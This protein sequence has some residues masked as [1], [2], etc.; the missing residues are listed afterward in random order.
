M[1]ALNYSRGASGLPIVSVFGD[2]KA[3]FLNL[4]YGGDDHL[5]LLP[6]GN[7]GPFGNDWFCGQKPVLD[8]SF[9]TDRVLG[10][11]VRIYLS[12]YGGPIPVL[13]REWFIPGGTGA[14]GNWI[15][16]SEHGLVMPSWEFQVHFY[17]LDAAAAGGGIGFVSVRAV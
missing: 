4:I 11:C 3:G 12:L 5:V 10:A 9:A 14:A 1:S 15:I 16:T 13:W 17:N 8:F 7:A 2:S 6:A